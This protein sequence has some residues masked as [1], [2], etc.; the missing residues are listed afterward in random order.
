VKAKKAIYLYCIRGKTDSKLLTKGIDGRGT[1]FTLTYQHL[2]AVV[3]EVSVREYDSEE[4]QQ[5]AR[6]DL[7]WIKEKALIHEAVIEAAMRCNGKI[8]AVIPM[9][10][11]TIFTSRASIQQ[12]IEKNYSKF[13]KTLRDLQGKQEWGVKIYLANSRALE[14]KVKNGNEVI[15][16]KAKELASM[17]K[18]AA[19]FFEKQI[20]ELVD[21]EVNNTI[22]TYMDAIFLDLELHSETGLKGKILEKELTGKS[23]PMVLNAFYLIQED[24]I[25]YFKWQIKRLSAE[26]GPK[27]F[28]LEYSGPWPPYNFARL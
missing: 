19:Y 6:E 7:N 18:G 4:I 10:F 14:D 15:K 16:A 21:S 20:R 27:G 9:C 8:I 12:T 24:R 22:G 13:E 1:V 2:E 26:M 5:K 11:G 25:E 17:S 3:S 23:E 28:R